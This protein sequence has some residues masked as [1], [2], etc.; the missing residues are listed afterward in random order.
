MNSYGISKQTMLPFDEA[1]A[2]VTDL[3]KTQGFGILMQIDVQQKIKEK[4]NKDMEKYLI[5]GACHPPSAYDALQNE[6][7]IGLL[8]P[9]NV[10]V[11]KQNGE[12]HV[13]AIR[14]RVAMSFVE[15]SRLANMADAVENKLETVISQM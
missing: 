14:P 1:V 11:Y 8:L 10:I 15:N 5:L 3:L 6:I 13:S 4:L 2:K 9:C 7:E 12:T